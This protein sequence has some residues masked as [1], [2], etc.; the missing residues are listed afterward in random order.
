MGSTHGKFLGD[1]PMMGVTL[2]TTF[3]EAVDVQ[4]N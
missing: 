4:V 1:V 3:F 2:L